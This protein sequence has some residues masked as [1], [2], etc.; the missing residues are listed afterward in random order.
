MAD[1]STPKA[2]PETER[3]ARF[4]KLFAQHNRRL[5]ALI[6]VLVSGATDAEEVFQN[7]STVLWAKFDQFAEGTDFWRWSSQIA[8]YEALAWRRK[9]TISG[10]LFSDR[11]YEAVETRAADLGNETNDRIIAL[12]E[13][14]DELEEPQRALIQARY[15][16][17]ASVR[18]IASEFGR[19]T[20]AIYKA[21]RRAHEWLFDCVEAKL[22]EPIRKENRS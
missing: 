16:P 21:L 14:V 15:R 6:R 17:G 9:C 3:T 7:T 22:N 10:K 2:T 11:F 20:N 13:C 1:P 5:Y 4:V 12:A 8:R 19:S 18:N